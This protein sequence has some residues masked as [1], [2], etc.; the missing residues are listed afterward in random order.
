MTS[1]KSLVS[2]P[3]S[4]SGKIFLLALKVHM[5]Y[6]RYAS[7]ISSAFFVFRGIQNVNLVSLHMTVSAYWCSF[8]G[9]WCHVSLHS[10]P[11]AVSFYYIVHASESIEAQIIMYCSHDC[12]YHCC[13]Y[14]ILV[15]CLFII[16]Q[17]LLE[18]AIFDQ[19]IAFPNWVVSVCSDE[20]F[21]NFQYLCIFFLYTY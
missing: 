14:H 4:L 10:S 19:R 7:T 13:W 11:E 18:Y 2:N 9:L 21:A 1:S 20:L 15:K 3:V 6:L 8:V 16:L 5:T 12:M 17:V